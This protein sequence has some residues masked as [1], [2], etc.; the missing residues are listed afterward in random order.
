MEWHIF[1]SYSNSLEMATLNSKPHYFEKQ[2][3]LYIYY[4]NLS[5]M[6]KK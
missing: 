6:F 1:V 2:K 4:Y 5:A 3:M